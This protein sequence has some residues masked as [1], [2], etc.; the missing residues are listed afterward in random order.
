[1]IV[2][3]EYTLLNGKLMRARSCRAE[4]SRSHDAGTHHVA[5]ADMLSERKLSRLL[6]LLESISIRPRREDVTQHGSLTV[7]APDAKTLHCTSRQGLSPRSARLASVLQS[8]FSKR[9]V[10]KRP[11]VLTICLASPDRQAV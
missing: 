2:P 3:D 4:P 9:A 11:G 8:S 7:P 1:M 5:E 10:F 6:R